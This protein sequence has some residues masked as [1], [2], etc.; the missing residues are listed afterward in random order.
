MP[1]ALKP[2][3]QR[4]FFL[5]LRRQLAAEGGRVALFTANQLPSHLVPRDGGVRVFEVF[6]PAPVQFG[7]L[8]WTEGKLC[9]ALR[10]T[11]AFP[12]RHR[13]LDSLSGWEL[14]KF[15]KRSRAHCFILSRVRVERQFARNNVTDLSGEQR[16]RSDELRGGAEIL[17]V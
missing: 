12:E 8:L 5:I 2:A 17:S 10:T 1:A 11:E 3:G 16:G 9:V 4:E 15:R 6:G 14:E 7:L 13:E